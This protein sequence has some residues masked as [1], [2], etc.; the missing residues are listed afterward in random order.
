MDCLF[1]TREERQL[2]SPEE[3][4]HLRSL[5]VFIVNE[6]ERIEPIARKVRG[7]AYMDRSTGILGVKSIP[8]V[9]DV[10]RVMCWRD[11]EVVASFTLK[12]FGHM[13]TTDG[14]WFDLKGIGLNIL[15]FT[16]GGSLSF[17]GRSVQATYGKLQAF[18]LHNE[19]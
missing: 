17:H 12:D 15:E 2:L 19:F 5:E 3:S 1:R 16:P 6:R 14:K 8:H 11:E 18:G 4:A 13:D 10:V 7:A 9:A